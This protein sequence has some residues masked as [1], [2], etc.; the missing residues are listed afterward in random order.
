MAGHVRLKPALHED[1]PDLLA[2]LVENGLKEGLKLR[3]DHLDAIDDEVAA[4]YAEPAVV[5]DARQSGGEP[6]ESVG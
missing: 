3:M 4:I 1:T 6:G 2:E 5:V